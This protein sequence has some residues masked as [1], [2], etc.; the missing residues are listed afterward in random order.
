MPCRYCHQY[1]GTLLPYLFTLTCV[2][3]R[4]KLWRAIGGVFS[5]ALSLGLPPVAVS[6][7]RALSCPDFPL[8]LAEALESDRPIHP[9]D[10]GIDSLLRKA[11]FI[12]NGKDT[13]L[14]S[15][16]LWMFLWL[17]LI[18]SIIWIIDSHDR[19]IKNIIDING[20]MGTLLAKKVYKYYLVINEYHG[21]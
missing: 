12:K 5:V 2:R 7:H 19:T 18:V 10:Y 15:S 21:S 3:R 6:H 14:M 11:H 13:L 8:S 17:G 20:H 4:I 9:K 1:R 16:L